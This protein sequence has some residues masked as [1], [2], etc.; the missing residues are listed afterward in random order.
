LE[1]AHEL[2]EQSVVLSNI[3]AHLCCNFLALFDEEGCT[4]GRGDSKEQERSSAI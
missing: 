2:I 3:S 4:I 1:G